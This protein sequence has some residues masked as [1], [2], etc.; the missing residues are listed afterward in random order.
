MKTVHRCHTCHVYHR[1]RT[2]DDLGIQVTTSWFSYLAFLTSSKATTLRCYEFVPNPLDEMYSPRRIA[3]CASSRRLNRRF[4]HPTTIRVSILTHRRRR[5][6]LNRSVTTEC[7]L[8]G[9][10][11]TTG[12]AV[13]LVAQAGHGKAELPG[14]AP[15]DASVADLNKTRRTSG[16]SRPA[17]RTPTRC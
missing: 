14:C 5:E 4:T 17:S 2:W 15:P 10:A 1:S 9:L 16:P 7:S 8:A 13:S 11:T 3:I 6:Q 12:E